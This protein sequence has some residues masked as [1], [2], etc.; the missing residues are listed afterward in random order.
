LFLICMPM[1]KVA[2]SFVF[3]EKS[4]YAVFKRFNPSR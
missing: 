1:L 2:L 3:T 4:H